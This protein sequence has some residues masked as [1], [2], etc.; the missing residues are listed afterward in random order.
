VRHTPGEAELRWNNAKRQSEEK[1]PPNHGRPPCLRLLARL[2]STSGANS[3]VESARGM[4]ATAN[5]AEALA[6]RSSCRRIER[7]T[8]GSPA[9]EPESHW[10]GARL[11]TSCVVD[12]LHVRP[13]FFE[14]RQRIAIFETVQHVPQAGL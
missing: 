5:W 1:V 11:W 8:S 7:P 4:K 12:L 13:E 10:I 3:T 9:R 2:M 6:R 14:C